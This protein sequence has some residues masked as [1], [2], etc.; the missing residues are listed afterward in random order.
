MIVKILKNNNIT[1]K[2]FLLFLEKNLVYKQ[3]IVGILHNNDSNK[4]L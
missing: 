2:N 3:Q 4:R 1:Y